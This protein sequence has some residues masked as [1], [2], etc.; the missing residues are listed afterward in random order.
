MKVDHTS[1]RERGP[2]LASWAIALAAGL[3]LVS[4]SVRAEIFEMKIGMV[5][6][7]DTQFDTGKKFAEEVEKRSGG[8]IKGKVFPVAQL[9]SNPRQ[10]EGV[11]L[12]T[13]EVYIGPP[14][15]SVGINA[16]FQVPDAPGLVDDI[17]H[18]QRALAH[19]AFRDKFLRLGEDK[20]VLGVTLWAYD[21]SSIASLTPIRTI[22]DLKGM[23]I[24]VL[25]TKMESK[26]MSEFG[27]AGVPMPLPAVLS[28]LQRKTVDGCRTSIAV[29]GALKYFTVTKFITVIES[30]VIPTMIEVSTKWLA[31]LP[32]DLRQIV[33]D[34]GKDIEPWAFENAKGH[35]ERAAK[36]WEDN[37]AE[38]IRL[39]PADQAEFMRRVRPLGDEF[40]ATNPATKEMYGIWK[41]ALAATRK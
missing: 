28:A 15:F 22:E 24:R 6:I 14:G 29:M 36:K 3:I 27:A 1:V 25:A 34:T 18:A 37:G 17:E 13:Q 35:V 10:I 19:P 20:G 40:L 7:N 8:R 41:Q 39:S 31:K 30:G 33:I 21:M 12:G 16:A 2:W 5:T 11:Q 23:K 4:G 26:L 38:V 9:G 32:P